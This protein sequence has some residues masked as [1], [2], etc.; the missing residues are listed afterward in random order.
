M[1]GMLH[2]RH[3]GR[4]NEITNEAWQTADDPRGIERG[5]TAVLFVAGAAGFLW[6]LGMLYVIA[7]WT[8]AD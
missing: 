6:L 8:L 5:V 4:M 1:R 3:A 7:T 2:D